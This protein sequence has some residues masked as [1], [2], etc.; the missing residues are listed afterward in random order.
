SQQQ[1]NVRP[2]K[3]PTPHK[4]R[5]GRDSEQRHENDDEGYQPDTERCPS[6]EVRRWQLR[7]GVVGRNDGLFR[8]D[9]RPCEGTV[10]RPH[11]VPS[12]S[13]TLRSQ[14]FFIR[15]FWTS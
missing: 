14:V 4:K 6:R 11:P 15:N 3:A 10:F 2:T 1:A 8:H 12:S 7:V 9:S 13:W 5:S